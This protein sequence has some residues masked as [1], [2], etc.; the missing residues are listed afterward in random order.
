MT[1]PEF[2]EL[3]D[4]LADVAGFDMETWHS[5]HKKL[6]YLPQNV[7]EVIKELWRQQIEN[8]DADVLRTQYTALRSTGEFNF[9]EE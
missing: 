6:F 8:A 2:S 4:K 3:V 9:S 1:K 7:E 5:H